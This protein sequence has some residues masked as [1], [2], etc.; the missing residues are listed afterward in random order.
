[1]RVR[2]NYAPEWRRIIQ[3]LR[4]QDMHTSVGPKPAGINTI[5]AVGEEPMLEALDI[6]EVLGAT[7]MFA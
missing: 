2:A 1:M 7:P 6:L 5:S 3:S 4:V